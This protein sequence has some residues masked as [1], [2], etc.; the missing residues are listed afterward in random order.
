MVTICTRF[1][2]DSSRSCVASS[3]SGETRCDWNQRSS[4]S[5]AAWRSP[6]SC[7]HSTRCSRLV[8]RRS[9]SGRASSRP[10][11]CSAAS[12]WRSMKPTPR[13][14]QI[15][16]QPAKRC[17]A[18]SSADSSSASAAMAAASQAHQLGGQRGLQ[19][20]FARRL[21]DGRQHAIELLGV[22]AAEHAGLRQ[23]DAADAAR[24]QRLADQRALRVA[25]HQ[26]RDVAGRQ[27]TLVGRLAE[28]DL[29]AL[30]RRQQAR[31]LG[32][33]G[34]DDRGLRVALEHRLAV[35]GRRQRPHLQRRARR[36]GV[37][38]RLARL[39]AERAPPGS[40]ARPA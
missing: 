11:T 23:L 20:A 28:R 9:P 22:A 34:G 13:C 15:S 24:R 16:R 7:R 29:A 14:S 10:A 38:Q 36:A 1:W 2:S 19:R 18:S 37:D 21:E 26:H 8:S 6:A 39:L 32:G 35:V 27:R 31:D 40:R 17:T 33:G 25:A 5:G 3:A 30:R 4:V 12:H